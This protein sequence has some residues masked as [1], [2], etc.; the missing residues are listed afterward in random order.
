MWNCL[1]GFNNGNTNTIISCSLNR[2][3]VGLNWKKFGTIQEEN[4]VQI[5]VAFG[6]DF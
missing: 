3:D 6:V 1:S 5:R 2:F 4:I